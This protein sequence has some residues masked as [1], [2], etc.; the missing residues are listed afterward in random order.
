M[1][2]ICFALCFLLMAFCLT[3]CGKVDE[4]DAKAL[5]DELLSYVEQGKYETASELFHRKYDGDKTFSRYLEEV[6]REFGLDFQSGIEISECQV[7]TNGPSSYY[8][9]NC[10]D[11]DITAVISGKDVFIIIDILEDDEG[12]KVF[13]F[14]VSDGMTQESTYYQFRPYRD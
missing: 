9:L 1:K 6:E 4:D 7:D 2:K 10:I 11:F 5:A 8:G 12:L 3:S 13:G 14:C